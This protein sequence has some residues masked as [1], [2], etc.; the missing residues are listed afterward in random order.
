MDRKELRTILPH[1]EPM[2]LVDE[3]ELVSDT[4]S[5]GSYFVR[6]DE[7]FL[8][9]H[10]PG[11]PVVPGVILC[12]ILAQ[13]SCVLVASKIKGTT[14][15]FTGLNRVRFKRKVAPG[16]TIE[17]ESVLVREKTPFYFA[18]ATGYVSGEAAVS[19][20]FSFMLEQQGE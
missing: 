12:E 13:A 6:G 3:A 20:E 16:D 8:Q 15:Y 4:R 19:A 17:I 11:N 5:R 1:R 18:E 10:F 9:G 7:W 14:P 2:L